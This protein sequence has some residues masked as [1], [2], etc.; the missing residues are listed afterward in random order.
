MLAIGIDSDFD[1]FLSFHFREEYGGVGYQ[2]ILDASSKPSD[3]CP[4]GCY[5][6]WPEGDEF[7][8]RVN[9]LGGVINSSKPLFENA[10]F[11]QEET[12]FAKHPCECWSL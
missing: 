9:L 11:L 4:L 6:N 8:G 1:P 10:H 2:S 12:A 3:D 7:D 5:W